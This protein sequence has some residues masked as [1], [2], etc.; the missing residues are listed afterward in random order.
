M[1]SE[2]L[3]KLGEWAVIAALVAATGYLGSIV[4]HNYVVHGNDPRAHEVRFGPRMIPATGDAERSVPVL[5]EGRQQPLLLLVMRTTCPYCEEN[6]SH[7]VDM[8]TELRELGAGAPEV[9]VLS[10]SDLDETRE[11][12]ARH[13]L[14]VPARHIDEGVLPLLGLNGFP[15]TVA[16]EPVKRGLSVWEGVLTDSDREA[17]RAWS[18]PAGTALAAGAGGPAG[19]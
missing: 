17:I 12:L 19:R 1:D 6:M 10:V 9:L 8:V 2:R 7:W 18:L 16:V 4:H 3:S 14:E 13:G 11:Y 15:S 5:L